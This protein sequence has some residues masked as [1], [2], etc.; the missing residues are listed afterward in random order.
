MKYRS[1]TFWKY[2]GS[3]VSQF[4]L[5]FVPTFIVV[6][7][8]TKGAIPIGLNLVK[9][10]VSVVLAQIVNF[11]IEMLVATLCL[12]T[13]ST[14]GINIVK[15]TIV[16]VLSGASIPLGASATSSHGC[17]SALYTTYPCRCSLTRVVRTRSPGSQN[18][19]V[20]S[21]AGA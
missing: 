12:Y 16:L 9:F 4:I 18:Y 15:E 17:L 2:S 19:G 20:C 14:W 10:M 5:A 3:H 21:S 7:I 1:Y 11:G 6:M 8:V 13:E